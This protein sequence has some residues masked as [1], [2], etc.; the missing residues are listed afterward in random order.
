M[1]TVDPWH[2]NISP[3]VARIFGHTNLDVR[4]HINN[5]KAILPVVPEEPNILVGNTGY[6]DR[7]GSITAPRYGQTTDSIGRPMFFIGDNVII[8]R[9][10]IGETLIFYERDQHWC[11]HVADDEDV[12][13]WA[14]EVNQWKLNNESKTK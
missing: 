9:Y 13:R 2:T 7:H 12:Q 6:W 5:F 4:N 3:D 8:Q 14:T 1:T 11:H 10:N